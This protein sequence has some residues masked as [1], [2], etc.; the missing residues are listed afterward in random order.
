MQVRLSPDE[1]EA[2]ERCAIPDRSVA[3]FFRRL[4]LH[5]VELQRVRDEVAQRNHP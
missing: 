4:A 3:A 2:I 1:Y 5:E